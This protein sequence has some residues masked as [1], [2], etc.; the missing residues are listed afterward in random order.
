[1][2]GTNKRIEIAKRKKDDEFYTTMQDVEKII[3]TFKD[4]IRGKFVFCNCDDPE[5]SNFSIYLR[6]NFARLGLK[7][8]VCLELGGR[9]YD[10]DKGDEI[11]NLQSGDFRCEESVDILKKCDIVITNP[12]FSLFIKY[13]EMLFEYG[14]DFIVIGSNLSVRK[15]ILRYKILYKKVFVYNILTNYYNHNGKTAR[16]ATYVYSNIHKQ[17]QP[18]KTIKFMKYSN[19][20]QQQQPK[21]TIKFMKYDNIDAIEIGALNDV[22]HDYYGVV[23]VSIACI[24][25]IDTDEY[26]V[27]G[28][29]DEDKVYTDIH[30]YE[31][32]IMHSPDGKIKKYNQINKKTVIEVT[33]DMID[34]KTTW[35][36]AENFKG[37]K[38]IIMFQRVFIR[39]KK[40]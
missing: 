40:K 5:K 29:S 8:L 12:P 13:M 37:K 31:G 36:E 35:Y 18:K 17:Q 24:N 6:E 33:D 7:R 16:V 27:I 21:K 3:E 2:K 32:G 20:Q 28:F 15:H 23:G 11:M 26:E 22:P 10:S 14:K 25:R 19:I 38:F 1:M 9:L 39:R 34:D 4:K 30:R